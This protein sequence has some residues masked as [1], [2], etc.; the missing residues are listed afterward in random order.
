MSR[1]VYINKVKC[2]VLFVFINGL[3][4]A[5]EKSGHDPQAIT[6]LERMNNL[7]SGLSSCSFVLSTATDRVFEGVTETEN[8]TSAVQLS[9]P[10][11]MQINVN[12]DKG[13]RAYYYNGKTL[14]YYSYEENNY[15]Q[16]SAPPSVLETFDTISAVYDIQ[17]PA[18]DFF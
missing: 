17:F 12:G 16:V 2:L 1:P 10:N 14:T 4:S 9:A 7:I 11:K 3:C 15:A 18:A 13:H 6:I 8:N 5:Q